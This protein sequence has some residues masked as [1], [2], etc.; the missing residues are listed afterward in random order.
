[1]QLTLLVRSYCHLCDEMLD[2]LRPLIGTTPLHVLDVD[3]PDHAGLEAQF[4]DAVPVLFAGSPAGP[5][6]LCRYRLDS[7]RVAAALAADRGIR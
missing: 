1:M 4:G 7:E 2:E 6:E 5:N 3:D